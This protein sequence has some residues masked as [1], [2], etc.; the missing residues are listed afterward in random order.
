MEIPPPSS[1]DAETPTSP[2]LNGKRRRPIN[3]GKRRRFRERPCLP[4]EDEDRRQKPAWLDEFT[5][6]Q[7]FALV[8]VLDV[9]DSIVRDLECGESVVDAQKQIIVDLENKLNAAQKTLSDTEKENDLCR[10]R[11]KR[12]DAFK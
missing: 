12:L 11:L 5:S 6:S 1:R 7:Q 9:R 2:T 10:K 8:K 4:E 3:G